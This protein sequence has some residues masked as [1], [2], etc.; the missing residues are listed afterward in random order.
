GDAYRA[1]DSVGAITAEDAARFRALGISDQRIS[2]TGDTRYD[3]VWDRAMR[4]ETLP[5]VASLRSRRP[6]LV[7]GSTWPS[8][9]SRLFAA[10][11]RVRTEIPSVRLL[12]APHEINQI[13]LTGLFAW[14]RAKGWTAA[15]VDEASPETDVIV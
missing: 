2:V 5:L 7:A 4:G 13:H 3:Q 6:T 1:L 8:D 15:R 12:I 14:F 11:E 10:W 9:E